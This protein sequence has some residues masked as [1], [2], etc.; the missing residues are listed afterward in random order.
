[1]ARRGNS[2]TKKQAKKNVKA[3]FNRDGPSNPAD[4]AR[5]LAE[6][7]RLNEETLRARNEL[8]RSE[9][10]EKRLFIETIRSLKD[11]DASPPKDM[12]LQP[13][14]AAR[15]FQLQS[16]K[17]WSW[18]D[19]DRAE[20]IGSTVPR[21]KKS[22]IE[23]ARFDDDESQ[24][25]RL[26]PDK[27]QLRD[28]RPWSWNNI[29]RNE[30]PGRIIAQTRQ[31]SLVKEADAATSPSVYRKAGHRTTKQTKVS[32]S[33][34]FQKEDDGDCMLLFSQL[35]VKDSDTRSGQK[36]QIKPQPS[37]NDRDTPRQHQ[38]RQTVVSAASGSRKRHCRDD[39]DG[40][41]SAD[42]IPAKRVDTGT[43]TIGSKI[44]ERTAAPSAQKAPS[45]NTETEL[46]ELYG[47]T[48][49]SEIESMAR[50]CQR[51]K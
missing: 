6:E 51:Y 29:G 39:D 21:P 2:I 9:E 50:M 30:S 38:Q 26:S 28:E 4:D 44:I 48:S 14:K 23:S 8:F 18:N 42:Y 19:V 25:R 34:R 24:P 22:V 37:R 17:P 35:V 13:A 16:E 12:Q 5:E 49:L 10:R 7:I 31:P 20:K 43:H 46:S 11:A 47:P 41:S 40:S 27:I 1:M 45:T 33:V 3:L 15:G 36:A 32:P